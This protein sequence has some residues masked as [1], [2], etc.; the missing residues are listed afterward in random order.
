MQKVSIGKN[1]KSIGTNAFKG[2]IKLKTIKGGKN[3]T[4]IGAKAFYGCKTLKSNDVN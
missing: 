4:K 3:L 1:V 2:C